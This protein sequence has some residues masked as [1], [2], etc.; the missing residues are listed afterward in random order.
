MNDQEHEKRRNRGKDPRDEEL[1]GLDA[2]RDKLSSALNDMYYLL[3][4]DYPPRATLALVGNRYRLRQRQILA[5][6]GMACSAND[7]ECRRAKEV[8]ADHLQEKTI[9]LD[10]FNIVIILETFLSGGYVFKGLDGCYRDISS[11]HGSYKRVKQTEEVLISAGLAL[12]KL[13]V[14][15]TTWIFDTPVSNSG[16]LMT[17]CYEIA[18]EHGFSWEIHLDNAPD[19]YLITGSRLI[20]SS[21]AWILNG[22]YQWFNF[23]SFMIN[24]VFN[25]SKALN[26]MDHTTKL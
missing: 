10:G 21:D 8:S 13:G 26:I 14:K 19:K 23:T 25:S 7:I 17:L 18:A 24:H 4:K 16:R 15:Q 9:F 22:C 11:V 2:Q 1:F 6:Q 3:S 20:A 5:L 12:Q